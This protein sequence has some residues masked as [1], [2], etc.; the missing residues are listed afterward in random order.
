MSYC[1]EPVLHLD[2]TGRQARQVK[3]L[4]GRIR[5]IAQCAIDNRIDPSRADELSIGQHSK[6]I[7]Q[8]M[9]GA[10]VGGLQ[11][12]GQGISHQSHAYAI[13]ILDDQRRSALFR[14]R[15]QDR[16]VVG[17]QSVVGQSCSGTV[18]HRPIVANVVA[19]SSDF[20]DELVH[21][22]GDTGKTFAGDEAG[23]NRQRVTRRD[24]RHESVQHRCD[25]SAQKHAE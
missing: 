15:G 17:R 3:P 9:G 16:P 5:S 7:T 12:A 14:Q 21:R 6:A 20:P 19:A 25:G 13:E 24:V 23:G 11:R 4:Y 10:Y 22:G 8:T 18:A 1:A 2:A